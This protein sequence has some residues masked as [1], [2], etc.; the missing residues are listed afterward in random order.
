MKRLINVVATFDTAGNIKPTKI[1]WD[2]FRTLDIDRITD[3]RRAA[4][5]KAG[6]TGIRYTCQINGKTRY[7][8]LDNGVWFVNI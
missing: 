3:I 1:L 8:F 2:D 5:L 6:G 7:L 4:C